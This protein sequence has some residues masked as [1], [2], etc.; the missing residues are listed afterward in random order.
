MT[1]IKL[2]HPDTLHDHI[3]RA[4]ESFWEFI[5]PKDY[6]GYLIKHNGGEPHPNYFNF[7]S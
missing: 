5:L 3:L 7:K 6:R 4:L 2:D 1:E